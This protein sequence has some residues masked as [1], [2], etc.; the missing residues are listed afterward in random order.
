MGNANKDLVVVDLLDQPFT[1]TEFIKFLIGCCFIPW[2]VYAPVLLLS[3]WAYTYPQFPQLWIGFW[4]TQLTL[5]LSYILIFIMLRNHPRII[6]IRFQKIAP[7]ANDS[8]KEQNFARIGSA[9]AIPGLLFIPYDAIRN[10]D[11]YPLYLNLVG[12]LFILT[13]MICTSIVMRQNKF[14]SRVVFKQDHQKLVTAGLYS[15]VRHPMY[16][17]ILPLFVGLSLCIGSLW[18]CIPMICLNVLTALR[19]YSEEHFLVRT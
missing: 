6:R 2:I 15:V 7:N 14:A 1:K 16:S 18:G 10:A 13:S 17:A 5:T 8:L 11:M 9:I 12:C 19:T 3:A 4:I